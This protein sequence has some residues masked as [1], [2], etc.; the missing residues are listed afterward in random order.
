[1]LSPLAQSGVA[2]LRRMRGNGSGEQQ[3]EQILELFS[4]SEDNETL[5]KRL[6]DGK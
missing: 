1:L 3:T 5:L 4:E 2:K 6:R